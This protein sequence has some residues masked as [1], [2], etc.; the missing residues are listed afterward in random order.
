MVAGKVIGEEQGSIEVGAK[1]CEW[2][3]VTSN[4]ASSRC[5]PRP[6]CATQQAQNKRS[7]VYVR[8]VSCGARAVGP[9]ELWVQ[10][11]VIQVRQAEG[12]LTS[13]TRSGSTPIPP[14]GNGASLVLDVLSA[15]RD[16]THRDL[17]R[18]GPPQ[19]GQGD[20]GGE[21]KVGTAE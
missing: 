3:R 13:N 21:P 2:Q 20:S 4:G 19:G 11:R 9:E 1:G 6:E 18:Q 15:E 17:D 7:P 5:A 16:R 8:S 12:E 14:H 10:G